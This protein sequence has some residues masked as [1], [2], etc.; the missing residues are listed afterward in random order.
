MAGQLFRF[1]MQSQYVN[2]ALAG[3]AAF[4]VLIL[5]SGSLWDHTWGR[6]NKGKSWREL[7]ARLVEV[8]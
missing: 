1:A 4:F 6:M 8:C 7:E 5:G 2:L 3:S